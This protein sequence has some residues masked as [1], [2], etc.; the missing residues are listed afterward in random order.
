VSNFIDMLLLAACF[1]ADLL[2]IPD[3]FVDIFAYGEAGFARAYATSHMFT[4]VRDVSVSHEGFF[5]SASM[6]PAGLVVHADGDFPP[7]AWIMIGYGHR[8]L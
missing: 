3:S 5:L 8:A 2:T 1:L 4:L 6:S 7:R